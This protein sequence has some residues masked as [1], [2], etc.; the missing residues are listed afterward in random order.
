LGDP[1]GS[2]GPA[3]DSA[4]RLLHAIGLHLSLPVILAIFVLVVLCRSAFAR[5]RHRAVR[6]AA[7]LT[8]TLRRRL[9]CAIEEGN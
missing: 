5:A 2:A 4:G 1:S 6:P 8:T 3:R 7:R 9:Y